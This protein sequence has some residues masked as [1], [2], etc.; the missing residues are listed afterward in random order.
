MKIQVVKDSTGHVLA[1]FERRSTGS[2]LEPQ[3]EAGQ[4]VEEVNVAENYVANL[5][6]VYQAAKRG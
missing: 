6:T 5:K 1:T 2:H 4:K 3:L